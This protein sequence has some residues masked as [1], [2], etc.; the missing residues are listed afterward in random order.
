MAHKYT[1]TVDIDGQETELPLIVP[2]N[3]A[4]QSDVE[5]GR[6]RRPTE[7]EIDRAVQHHRRG[8]T[9][10]GDITGQQ[11][12]PEGSSFID[13]LFGPAE[14]EAGVVPDTVCR[15]VRVSTDRPPHRPGVY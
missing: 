8:P 5:A 13:S 6:T 12:E 2:G 14:A 11:G 4:L 1:A 3:E 15:T 7:E 9:G 10:L